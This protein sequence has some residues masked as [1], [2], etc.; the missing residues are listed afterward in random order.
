MYRAMTGRYPPLHVINYIWGNKAEIGS[1][2]SNPSSERVAMIV[3][4][5]GSESLNTWH[6]E[7]RNVYLDYIRAFG[8]KPTRISDIAIMT[9]TDNTGESAVAYFGDITFRKSQ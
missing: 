6:N 1:M 7:R 2:V 4:R 5:S 9:D 8:Q 3:V